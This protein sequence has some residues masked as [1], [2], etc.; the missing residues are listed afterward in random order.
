MSS[1]VSRCTCRTH[2]LACNAPCSSRAVPKGVRRGE[3]AV[4]TEYAVV[5]AASSSQNHA[6]FFLFSSVLI[7]PPLHSLVLPT[8]EQ[9][10]G[11]INVAIVASAHT[12]RRALAGMCGD[13]GHAAI[14]CGLTQ[15][16]YIVL[17][18]F[19][20]EVKGVEKNI[21][22]IFTRSTFTCCAN[23]HIIAQSSCTSSDNQVDLLQ[24]S[25]RHFG[26]GI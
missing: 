24:S 3:T 12:L 26:G 19:G 10:V 20:G 4:T 17:S 6:L 9:T 13:D 21:G 15:Y 14:V 16:I 8:S 7:I 18:F 25:A 23:G 11:V 22:I 2:L 5:C 1:K